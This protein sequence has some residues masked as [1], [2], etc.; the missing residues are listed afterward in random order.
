MAV[1]RWRE[2]ATCD[3][4]GSYIFLR[5]V[6]SGDVWSAGFQPT[7]RRAGRLR[8]DLQ[9]GPRGVH[10]PRR[11][12]DHDAGGRW[13]RP[14]TTPK[15]AASRSPMPAA[16]RARSRS[17]P[18]PSSCWR[19]RPPTS[20][21]RPSRSCSCETEYLAEA[22]RDPRDAA[23]ALA[24]RAGDLG[25][26]SR[27][28]RRRGASAS[29]SSKPTARAS[30]AAGDGV[31]RRRSRCSTAGR[32]RNTVG[33]VLDPIFA[34]RRRVRI[35]PGATARIAF[36][37]MVAPSR[38]ALLDLVDKHRDADGLRA[39]ATLAWT[40]A[41]VQLR[42]LG[43]DPGEA[44]LFQRLAGHVLYADP[45]LR[46]VLGHDPARRRPAIGAV[47]AG[48]FRRSADRAAA[49][50]RHRGSRHRRASCCRRTNTGG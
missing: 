5:D 27:G 20:R 8:S 33:T 24:G 37:T 7:R 30:S 39:R 25:R 46:P 26:A 15:C 36:W 17:P 34:L 41:Q 32:C 11:H 35:A 28:R 31:A 16:A 18:T 47:G 19:R 50:R 2:D 49:H 45:A 6:D 12:A 40:Q 21:I 43:I 23:P 1:T 14:R 42:H 22:R 10:A 48:H 13:S 3:D 38:E 4:W 29:R 9:R 44:G